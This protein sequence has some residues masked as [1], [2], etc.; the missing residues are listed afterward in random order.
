MFKVVLFSLACCCSLG[1]VEAA[2]KEKISEL[3]SLL[4]NE[5]FD[6]RENA[7]RQLEG[8]GD[9]NLHELRVA[10]EKSEDP[11]A[12]LRLN[13]IITRVSEKETIAKAFRDLGNSEWDSSKAAISAILQRRKNKTAI[14]EPLSDLAKGTDL[15]GRIAAEIQNHFTALSRFDSIKVDAATNTA[16]QRHE[17]TMEA[18]LYDRCRQLLGKGE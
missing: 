11:E 16:L 7:A 13:R 4:S 2:S 18:A 12:R 5:S 17:K 6:L 8:F 1:A 10:A 14:Q 15:R 9:V 3:V